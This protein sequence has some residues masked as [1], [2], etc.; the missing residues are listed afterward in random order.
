M[1]K[2]CVIAWHHQFCT[3]RSIKIHQPGFSRA[4]V[5][6][7]LLGCGAALTGN[8]KPSLLTVNPSLAGGITANLRSFVRGLLRSLS[9]DVPRTARVR[10]FPTPA[11]SAEGESLPRGRRLSRAQAHRGCGAALTHPHARAHGARRPAEGRG[12]R[13]A[14]LA[15]LMSLPGGE[16]GSATMCL[17]SHWEITERPP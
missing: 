14:R 15:L 3:Q 4:P 9:A 12:S 1:P 11:S 6:S 8:L 7:Y 16:K 5:C 2:R 13:H 10:A 17:G